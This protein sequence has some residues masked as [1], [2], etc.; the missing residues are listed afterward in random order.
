MSDPRLAALYDVLEFLASLQEANAIKVWTRLLE[1]TAAALNAEAAVYFY[2]DALARQLVA[3]HA[4]GKD[5]TNAPGEPVPSGQGLAGWVAKYHEPALVA[6]ASDDPRVDPKI[7]SAQGIEVKTVMAV[8][9]FVNLD[10]C[11]VYEF[12]NKGG[13]AFTSEDLRFV[14]TVIQETSNTLRRLQL[15]GMVNRVT[16]YN[17]SILDNLSGGFLAVD[18][19]G[20]V[21]ILNPAG[22]KML[23]VQGEATDQPIEKALVQVPQ[24][25]EVLR[26]T[27]E[28]QETLKRQ[29]IRWTLDGAPKV[30][31]FSTLLIKDTHGAIAGAGV[32]FQDI[33]GKV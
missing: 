6:S 19:Q 27:L 15:E 13:E 10:F 7:D 18:L 5:G 1:K 23:G 26:R 33:T 31:G 9:L 17:S 25:A 28:T 4:L 30:L 11:G 21:M 32:S 29:E 8:P 22:R 14:K 16:T 3:F 2:H 20:R 24:L 12:M